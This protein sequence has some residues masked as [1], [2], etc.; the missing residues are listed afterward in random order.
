MSG[1][2]EQA[3]ELP[4][5]TEMLLGLSAWMQSYQIYLLIGVIGCVCFTLHL[6]NTGQLKSWVSRVF[7]QTPGL[8]SSI[9]LVNRIQV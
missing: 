7:S 6:A 8:K 9:L 2:F 4:V 1:L 3:A 5:Y